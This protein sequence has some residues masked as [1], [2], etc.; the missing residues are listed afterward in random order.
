M[1]LEHNQDYTVRAKIWCIIASS[2]N[3]IILF[4]S[5]KHE[6]TSIIH[7]QKNILSTTNKYY[8]YLLNT[9]LNS[10]FYSYAEI[11]MINNFQT[12]KTSKENLINDYQREI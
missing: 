7:S 3:L 12:I 4:L 1:R 10:G 8:T 9:E 11:I 6:Y 5:P 2:D